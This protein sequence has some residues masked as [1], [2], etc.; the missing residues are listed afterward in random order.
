MRGVCNEEKKCFEYGVE[1]MG[2]D[3]PFLC[4]L[5]KKRLSHDK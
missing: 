5:Q 2:V 3:W 4:N 1:K